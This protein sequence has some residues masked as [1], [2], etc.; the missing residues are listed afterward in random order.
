M[1]KCIRWFV[2]KNR[3]WPWSHLDSI[4]TQEIKVSMKSK[5]PDITI[6]AIMTNKD[7][8]QNEKVF[9]DYFNLVK[10]VA[11]LNE[12]Y[13]DLMKCLQWK[14]ISPQIELTKLV[15]ADMNTLREPDP[16]NFFVVSSKS[17]PLELQQEQSKDPSIRQVMRLINTNREEN[18]TYANHDLRK[19][20][21]H[22]GWLFL[23]IG[24][25][26]RQFFNDVG[27]VS[28]LQFC[29]PKQL[30]KE[31]YCTGFTTHNWAAIWD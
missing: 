24:V 31:K 17:A 13:P 19:Y 8:D 29:V 7:N 5:T 15:R 27:Q 14:E 22:K 25:L 9:E 10:K 26:Y 3:N 12:S 1:C 28:H 23:L 6:N 21:K 16:L 30:R 2:V 11:R 4:P 18:M 20:A